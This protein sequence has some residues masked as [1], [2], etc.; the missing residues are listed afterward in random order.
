[1]G[2]KQKHPYLMQRWSIIKYL[3]KTATS[4]TAVPGCES[5]APDSE[6]AVP[7]NDTMAPGGTEADTMAHWRD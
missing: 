3:R 4:E 7:G 1:M 2:Y 5:D 6:T